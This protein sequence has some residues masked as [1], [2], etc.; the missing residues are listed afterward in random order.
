MPLG[1][2]EMLGTALSIGS[3]C[4]AALTITKTSWAS[5]AFEFLDASVE[6]GLL[7]V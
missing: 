3:A 6:I 2:Q 7:E 1:P 5:T 4:I